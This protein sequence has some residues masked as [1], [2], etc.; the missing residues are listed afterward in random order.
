MSV[1][2]W[3]S[4]MLGVCNAVMNHEFDRMCWLSYEKEGQDEEQTLSLTLSQCF[5]VAIVS[6]KLLL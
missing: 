3:E 4:V 2:F 5:T 6:Q 1:A